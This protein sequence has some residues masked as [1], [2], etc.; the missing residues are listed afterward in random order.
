ML[1][2]SELMKSMNVLGLARRWDVF[3]FYNCPRA[4]WGMTWI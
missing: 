3:H 2:A 4:L 1:A